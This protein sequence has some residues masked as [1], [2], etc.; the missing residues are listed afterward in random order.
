MPMTFV[1]EGIDGQNIIQIRGND[2]GGRAPE[3]AISR[4]NLF[5]LPRLS[6]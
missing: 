5:R 2:G 4:G 3:V 6:N 1:T